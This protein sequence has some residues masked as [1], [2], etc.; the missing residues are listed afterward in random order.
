MAEP[1][2]RSDSW[3][4][5]PTWEKQILRT[6]DEYAEKLDFPVLDNPNYKLAGARLSA[7]RADSEW[8]IVFEVV[9]VTKEPQ[10]VIA[11]YAYGNKVDEPGYLGNVDFIEGRD[12]E[13]LWD[14]AT[15]RLDPHDFVIVLNGKEKQYTPTP[16]DYQRIGI[17]SLDQDRPVQLLRFI[18]EVD[19]SAVYLKDRELLEGCR[20]EKSQLEKFIQVTEWHHPDVGAG[21]KP[22]ESD[23]F[24]S[25]ASALAAGDPARYKCVGTAFNTHWRNWVEHG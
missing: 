24:Q 4:A 7:F 5:H 18:M 3:V 14:G 1:T 9:S 6:L 11:Y 17:T 8:L 16:A 15:L 13:D 21:G 12:G 2:A 23:C 22:S 20:R 10:F 19:A 25:L